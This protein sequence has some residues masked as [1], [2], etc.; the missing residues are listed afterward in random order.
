MECA[1]N[2][3]LVHNFLNGIIRVGLK[4]QKYAQIGRFEKFFLPQERKQ[5][6]NFGLEAWPGFMATTK[7]YKAG[8]FLNV[9]TTT[10]FIETQTIL[11]YI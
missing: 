10:K 9:D 11:D 6:P 2:E 5:I 8:I 3:K 1:S 4:E 7:L